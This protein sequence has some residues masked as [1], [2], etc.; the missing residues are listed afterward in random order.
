G[1]GDAKEPRTAPVLGSSLKSV[2]EPKKAPSLNQRLVP[3]KAMLNPNGFVRGVDG[4]ANVLVNPPVS[5]LIVWINWL[6]AFCQST[7]H[8]LGGVMLPTTGSTP[9]VLGNRFWAPAWEVLPPVEKSE[10]VSTTR[11]YCT[12]LPVTRT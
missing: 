7:P 9:L 8:R 3:S 2:L 5:V 4:E 1:V 10:P 6:G 12:P 11:L